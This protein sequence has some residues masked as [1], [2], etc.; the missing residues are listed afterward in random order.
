[1]LMNRLMG[2]LAAL[3]IIFLTCDAVAA[4]PKNAPI[5]KGPPIEMATRLIYGTNQKPDK[6]EPELA[7]LIETLKKDFG[8]LTYD[9]KKSEKA[10][11]KFDETATQDLGGDL[12]FIVRNLGV[13]KDQRKVWL[14]LWFR[15]KKIFGA[16]SLFPKPCKPLLIKGP[17]TNEGTYIIMLSVV[18]DEIK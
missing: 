6:V 9:V 1:M 4:E 18:G 16:F 12:I 8:Y 2:A 14:E 17:N 15:E 13:Y 5:V 7:K 11:L 10:T 3:F